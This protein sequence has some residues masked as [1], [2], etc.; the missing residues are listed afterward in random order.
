MTNVPAGFHLQ[1]K[2]PTDRVSKQ[3]QTIDHDQQ[4]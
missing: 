1:N 2:S 3:Q 4:L